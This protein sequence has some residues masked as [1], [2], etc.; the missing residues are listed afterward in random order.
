MSVLPGSEVYELAWERAK[1]PRA[2]EVWALGLLRWAL[3]HK[4]RIGRLSTC[5]RL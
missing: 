3:R 1:L 2:L 5:T 4:Q